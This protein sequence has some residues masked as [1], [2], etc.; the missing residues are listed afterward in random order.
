MAYRISIDTPSL[1]ITAVGKDRL[2]IFRTEELKR[3]TAEAITEARLS[4]GFL[5]FAYVFMPDHVHF[6]TDAPRKPSE[7]LQYI[8]GIVARRVIG[9]LKT[10]NCETSL[11]KLQHED[12]KRNHRYSLWQHDSDIFSV[13]SESK[14]ME[15]VNYIHMNPVRA[16]LV[17]RPEDYKWSSARWWAGRPTEDE[18]LKVDLEKIIWRR[19]VRDR[20]F[21]K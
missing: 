3:I 1:F 9:H 8:K 12:W 15:K 7:V 5:L 4:C 21:R 10:L 17:E 13:T 20:R 19:A 6:L 14:F 18:P 2:P 11:Q 16:G